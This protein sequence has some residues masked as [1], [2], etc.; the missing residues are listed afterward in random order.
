M[1]L[2]KLG[3]QIFSSR[4]IIGS[5]RYP[6][7]KTMCEAIEASG[8]EI[9]TVAVRRINLQTGFNQSIL[10]ILDPRLFILPNTAGCFTSKE[11][12]LTAELSREALDTNWIKLEV[13]G[14]QKTLYPDVSELLK[15]A[16]IL[17]KK[18]FTV[19]P[20]CT[21]DPIVCQ[22]LVDLGCA[23]IMPLGSPIGSGMGIVNP[24]NLQIIRNQITLPIIVDAGIGTASDV[25]IAMELGMDGVMI[26]TAIAQAH[27][28]V[29]M[30]KGMNLACQAGR[31][32]YL[33]G[34]IPKKLYATASSPLEG[35]L[36]GTP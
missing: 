33:S 27:H 22:K 31:L 17:V 11:A 3:D 25:A 18:G 14:D 13:I 32:A 35:V 10:T 28:P 4:L 15:A 6:D 12:V 34:R 2:L 23:A 9:V 20:Y 29:N 19:L 21:D 1:D 8:A 16:D 30:A 24:Y 7:P 26:N 5:A 36:N